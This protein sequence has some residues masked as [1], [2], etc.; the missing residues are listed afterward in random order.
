VESE[1]S[2]RLREG[3]DESWKKRKAKVATRKP[4]SGSTASQAGKRILRAAVLFD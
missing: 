1:R 4:S 3:L 2:H